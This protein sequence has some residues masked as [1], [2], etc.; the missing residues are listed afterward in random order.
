MM[1]EYGSARQATAD[2][3][4]TAHARCVLDN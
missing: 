4:I 3:I 1:E 2:N